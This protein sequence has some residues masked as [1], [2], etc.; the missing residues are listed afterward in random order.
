MKII[1]L[2][3]IIFLGFI[4]TSKTLQQA[5][6]HIFKK[7]ANNI[8]FFQINSNQEEEKLSQNQDVNYSNLQKISKESAN[9]TTRT[10]EIK[11]K[12]NFFQIKSKQE[13]EKLS[14][15]Q[16]L[17]SSNLQEPSRESSNNTIEN[18]LTLAESSENTNQTE[19]IDYEILE[20]EY[21]GPEINEVKSA[22][23]ISKNRTL[24]RLEAL[25]KQ[26]KEKIDMVTQALE[27][28]I[29]NFTERIINRSKELDQ[30]LLFNELKLLKLS[31]EIIKSEINEI[32]SEIFKLRTYLAKLLKHFSSSIKT[33]CSLYKTCGEC[34]RNKHCGWCQEQETCMMGDE[35]AP[36]FDL[37]QFY[38]Y[39]VCEGNNCLKYKNCEVFYFL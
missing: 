36:K 30:L 33:I 37:C 28:K 14:Q 25:T 35:K 9:K 4:V 27:I 26:I 12:I 24:M 13:Q 23:N 20:H 32:I 1:I 6:P 39:H 11:Q 29:N 18:N 7:I 38:N 16:D 15:N 2:V 3:S 22:L 21:Y 17:S 19:S 31:I 5:K 8:N 10:I 34:L